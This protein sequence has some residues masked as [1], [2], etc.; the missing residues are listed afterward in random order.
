LKFSD[1]NSRIRILSQRHGSADPDLYKNFMDL[2]HWLCPF[3]KS[4][5]RPNWPP[6]LK[7]MKSMIAISVADPDPSDPY[8]LDL[9][10]PD[11][12]VKD[13]APDPSII[14]QK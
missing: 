6:L 12:L 11:L 3:K 7:Y 4:A 1:E 5:L 13:P 10:D 9:L 2:Q 14:K 8:V